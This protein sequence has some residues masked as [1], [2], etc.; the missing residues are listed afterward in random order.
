MIASYYTSLNSDSMRSQKEQDN[1][2]VKGANFSS[3]LL[4]NV[5]PGR[6]QSRKTDCQTGKGD[7]IKCVTFEG[8]KAKQGDDGNFTRLYYM[9]GKAE[10]G[11]FC[12]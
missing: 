5:Y 12:N 3:V 1:N 6:Y 8:T 10:V 9:S 2:G 7:D 11:K 4:D